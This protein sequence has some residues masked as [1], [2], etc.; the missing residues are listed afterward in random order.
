MDK[1]IEPERNSLRGDLHKEQEVWWDK[2]T[3]ADRRRTRYQEIAAV[4]LI[5]FD[6]LRARLAKL[7]NTRSLAERE[8]V[9][10]RIQ[11]ERIGGLKA[12]RGA[13]LD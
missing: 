6:E 5:T 12:E 1:R 2:L 7:D 11:R 9:T 8:L 4:G 3:E 13:L 10:L